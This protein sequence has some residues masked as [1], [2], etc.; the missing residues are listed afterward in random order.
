M[1]TPYNTGENDIPLVRK[2]FE[3]AL[4][5]LDMDI[6]VEISQENETNEMAGLRKPAMMQ[7]V[8]TNVN[9]G[10]TQQTR[11]ETDPPCLVRKATGWM[12]LLDVHSPPAVFQGLFRRV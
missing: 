8:S 7:K 5:K 2:R 1:W 9:L 11:E 6:E 4:K 12:V 10:G 3:D